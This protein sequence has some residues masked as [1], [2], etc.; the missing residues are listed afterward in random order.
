VESRGEMTKMNHHGAMIDSLLTG[1]SLPVR[2]RSKCHRMC[3][4][5]F[6]CCVGPY[7]M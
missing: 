2:M 6:A 3:G 7:L 4:R 5:N 1:F